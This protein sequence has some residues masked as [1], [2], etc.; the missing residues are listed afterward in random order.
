MT[1]W[2]NQIPTPAQW[3]AQAQRLWNGQHTLLGSYWA[4]RLP[5]TGLADLADTLLSMGNLLGA[6][7]TQPYPDVWVHRTADVAESARLSGP[8]VVCAG[9]RIRPQAYVRGSVLVGR[10]AVVGHCTELKNCVLFDEAAA[11]H[12]NYIGDSVLGYRAHLGAGAVLSNVRGD[13]AN[14]RLHWAAGVVATPLCKLGSLV[15]DNV[16]IGCH[17]VLNPGCVI[18]SDARIYPLVGLRGYVSH[19][20]IVA[21][22]NQV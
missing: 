9:A 13:K 3:A 2:D 4:T 21:Q 19:G 20:A 7:Y 1:F 5:W 18:E 16:E 11:P 15:G 22:T 14:V 17:A 8:C 10:D 12:F 6:E